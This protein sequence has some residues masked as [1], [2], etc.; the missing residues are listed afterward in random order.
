[1][2]DTLITHGIV[3][4]MDP[5]RRVIEDGALAIDGERIVAVGTTA[6]MTAAHSA[7]KT[8]DAARMVVMPGLVD[9]HAHAGH[10]LVKTLGCDDS[11]AWFKA[12]EKIYSVGSTEGFWH[13]EAMLSALERLKCGTTTGVTFFGGG[14]SIMR[15]DAPVFGERHCQAI[16]QVGIRNFLAVGPCRPPFP[17]T[18]ARHQ[19]GAWREF[20]VSMDDILATCETLIG[21]WHGRCGNRVHICMQLPVYGRDDTPA[22]R[23]LDEI[24]AQAKAVRDMSREHG[25]LFTQDGHK[26]GSI[27]FAQRH[28]DLLGPDAFLSHCVDITAEE[29]AILRDTDTRVVHNPS[30]IM[31]VVGRCPVPEL[32]DAGVT[33]MLGSDGTA[34]DRSYDM[35]R[36]MS[37]G[38]H[39][40]RFHFRDS[41]YLPPGKMLEMLTIDAARALGLGDEIGS[42]EPGKRADVILVDMAKPHLYPLNMPLSRI[43]YFANGTDVDTVLVNGRVLMEGRSVL[44]VDE[45]DVLDQAQQETEEMLDRTDLRHLLE[46]RPN[47]WGHSRYAEPGYTNGH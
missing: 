19:G 46:L 17:R 10:G 14:D 13:A 24:K 36:H 18:Y 35:F 8:I 45:T 41:S 44:T 22:G 34:P 16:E 32:L 20:D 23:E 6:E 25:V 33:V 11:T 21:R 40:H 27:E 15:T 3:V 4:T 1:M 28:F 12:C 9:G 37:H 29:I 2:I 43:A 39:Y 30:A 5:E 7:R 26:S 42:L 38:M 31:S 47:F